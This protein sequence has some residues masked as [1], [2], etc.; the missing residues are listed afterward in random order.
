MRIHHFLLCLLALLPLRVFT[1]NIE[2]VS[3]NITQNTTWTNDKTYLLTGYVYVKNGASLTIQ[4]GTVIQGDKL[5]K[6]TLIIT[7]GAKIIA[8]GKRS[9]PIV[10][11][12]NQPNPAPGDW[13]GVV[14]CGF[15]PTN[16]ATN[17]MSCLGV[18]EGGINT[19]TNDARYGSGDQAGGCGHTD[20]NSGI[21]RF[22]RIE[23]GGIPFQL[24][25]ETNGLTLAGVGSGTTIDYVE[26]S[27]SGDDGFEFFGGTVNCK[28]LISY[29]NKDDDFDFDMGY[30][31]NIQFAIGIRDPALSDVSGSNGLE[32]DNDNTGTAVIPKTKPTLSNITLV[33]PTGTMDDNFRRAAHLRRNSEPALFNSLFIGNFP[34]GLYV[35]GIATIA[36]AQNNLLEIKHTYFADANELL[37]ATDPGFNISQW[38]D[39][40]TWNNEA[41]AS[42]GPL[43]LQSP[44][45]ISDPNA[46]P[47]SGSS[48]N[49]A[50]SFTMPRANIS[51]FEKVTY[52]GAFSAVEDWSCGW[53][54]Y[55]VLN[56]NCTVSSP[57]IP[58]IV[59]DIKIS[60]NIATEYINF[61]AQFKTSCDLSIDIVALNGQ[62]AA[63][64]CNENVAAGAFT[65]ALSVQHLQPGFYLVRVRAGATLHT[66]K[67]VIR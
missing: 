53:A 60:P 52:I 15:A 3:G 16:A 29:G 6:G 7:R 25:N 67:L 31:G 36:N 47:L 66:E 33:G 48:V 14:V 30:Q 26:V 27:H 23:Y 55:E 1:Q 18:A 63:Q 62:V 32:I 61:A 42:S 20:D 9:Q 54:K 51:F 44:F 49:N 46:Q 4:P 56:T 64:L 24:N 10:F 50:A 17:G 57:E 59:D 5:S 37:K 12:S 39:N 28:H 43:A 2:T 8:D 38:F 34:V 11:T 41:I 21:L 45:N 40:A 19:P 58:S 35:D 22:V 65:R 13:G